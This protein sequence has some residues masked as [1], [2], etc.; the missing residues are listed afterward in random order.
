MSTIQGASSSDLWS[1]LYR[2]LIQPTQGLLSYYTAASQ[3]TVTLLD[4]DDYCLNSIYRHLGWRD[5]V[6]CRSVCR[7]LRTTVEEYLNI[8]KE[9]TY[10]CELNGVKVRRGQYQFNLAALDFI[11]RHMPNL[12]TLRFERCSVMRS[13]LATCQF[14]LVDRMVSL[15]YDL[16]ELHLTRTLAIGGTTI[17]QLATRFPELTHLTVSVFNEDLL[18]TIVTRFEHLRYLN[19]DS[20]IL[21]GYGP[22]LRRLPPS[23]RTLIMPADLNNEKH[24]ILDSLC[25]GLWALTT[26]PLTD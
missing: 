8:Q 3:T 20:S 2:Q 7:R 14:N 10:G 19:L 26:H 9:L 23:I 1:V 11:L 18:E 21:C 6:R 25:Q 15:L 5:L 24:Q 12:Q 16:R 17:S 22:V 13:T 4:L